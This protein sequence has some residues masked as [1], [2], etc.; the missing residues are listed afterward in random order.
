M[1]E[2]NSDLDFKKYKFKELKVYS[3]TEWLANN[4]KKY[5]QVFDR[6]K[7]SYVYA[8][9]TFYNK[10]FDVK[11]WEANILFKCYAMK[12]K[13]K[14]IC[15]LKFK[16]KISKYDNVVY[17]REGW[18]NKK[19]GAFWKP[20]TYFW[21]AY[22]E[23]TLIATKY[24]YVE[25]IN[26]DFENLGNSSFAIKSLQLYEGQFDDVSIEDKKYYKNFANP[27]LLFIS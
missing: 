8:E 6:S 12:G 9:L 26:T 25:E 24:F 10:Y 27:V 18:G 20:G 14:E 21:E 5:R 3:S 1:A 4:M 13:K 17:I 11:V 19:D 15:A 7:T 23:D 2:L 22:I 16:K